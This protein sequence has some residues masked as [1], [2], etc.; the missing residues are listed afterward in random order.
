MDTSKRIALGCDEAAFNMKEELKTFISSL[1]FT[2]KDFGTKAGEEALYPDISYAVA[3]SIANGENDLAILCCGTGIGMAI[4]AN[5]V[6]GIRAAQTHDTYSAARARKSN[7]AQI[8]T[9][10]A[11]VVGIEL[12]KII[13]KEFLSA[14]FEATRSGSKVKLIDHYEGLRSSRED[15]N[16]NY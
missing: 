4:T 3:K 8:A 15:I 16:K 10:G 13:V 14:D 1:G 7:N 12:A 9:I 6:N 2:V 5:K 11:R